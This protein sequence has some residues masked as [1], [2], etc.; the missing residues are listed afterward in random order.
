[1]KK[2]I[3]F[4]YLLFPIISF[5]NLHGQTDGVFT[6]VPVVNGK[7]V[8]QQFIPNAE[9]VDAAQQ[10]ARLQKWGKNTFQRNPLLTGIRFDDKA[11]SMTISSGEV[12]PVPVLNGNITMRY[13]FDVSISNAGYMLVVRDITYQT[14][15]TGTGSSIP[16]AYPAEEMIT[17]QAVSVSDSNKDLRSNTRNATLAFLNDLYIKLSVI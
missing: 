7:V 11:R 15:Q 1:M 17:D 9:G 6:S 5:V 10:Y 14:E 4:I 13:R 16:K 8:F 3:L 12:L 2:T